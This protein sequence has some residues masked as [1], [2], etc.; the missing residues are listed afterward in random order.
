METETGHC[1]AEGE[2]TVAQTRVGGLWTP[3]ARRFFS[4]GLDEG[5]DEDMEGASAATESGAAAQ[6][7]TP[8][9][10]SFFSMVDS[11]D[12]GRTPDTVCGAEL[13]SASTGGASAA[14]TP[15]ALRFFSLGADADMEGSGTKQEGKE[16]EAETVKVVGSDG[17]RG[18]TFSPV[19]AAAAR[20][21]APTHVKAVSGADEAE[22][23]G[24][25]MCAAP[26][27]DHRLKEG[28]T[29]AEGSF[30][31]T[32][33]DALCERHAT[34]RAS[35]RAQGQA[36]VGGS[37]SRNRGVGRANGVVGAEEHQGAQNSSN[38]GDSIRTDL[39]LGDTA[40]TMQIGPRD[41]AV[42]EVG[43]GCSREMGWVRRLTRLSRDFEQLERRLRGICNRRAER[44][45]CCLNVW[46]LCPIAPA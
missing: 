5:T 33:E 20:P 24:R 22:N 42:G 30:A 16:H 19:Q 39:C 45:V 46:V 15:E 26:S 17:Q 1:G 23:D 28:S 38:D 21:R 6:G 44:C 31:Q 9:A 43:A 40:E 27:G 34:E 13:Q 25:R 37:E 14:W 10:L 3:E 11:G 8:Q 2:E 18:L 29:G 41:L 12:A 36:L 35:A 32:V 7:W 4:L